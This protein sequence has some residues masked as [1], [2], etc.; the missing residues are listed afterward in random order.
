MCLESSVDLVLGTDFGNVTENGTATIFD[1]FNCREN[2]ILFTLS[3]SFFVI[4]VI[5]SLIGNSL[6]IA[7]IIK[8]KQLRRKNMYFLIGSLALSDMLVTGI[9]PFEYLRVFFPGTSKKKVCC[10]VY[11]AIIL[12]L[13][14]SVGGNFLVISFERLVAVV[15]PLRHRTILTRTRLIIML[16]IV[17][18]VPTFIAFLPLFGWN[19]FSQLPYTTVLPYCTRDAVMTCAYQKL[20]IG[21]FVIC[22]LANVIMFIPVARVACRSSKH[23]DKLSQRGST[24][25]LTKLLVYTFAVFSVCWI[26]FLSFTLMMILYDGSQIQCIRQWSI[27]IGLIHSAVDWLIYGLG[28]KTFRK[29]FKHMLFCEKKRRLVLDS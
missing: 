16:I 22:M 26:P 17:W 27:H 20:I 25:R 24:K 6:V 29:A 8:F 1:D 13:F 7:S 10:L 3:S 2:R 18:T 5:S 19:S 15:F 9:A 11:F 12:T 28:N 4:T 14:G 23:I 21:L